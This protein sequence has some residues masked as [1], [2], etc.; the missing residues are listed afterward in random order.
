[1]FR[2]FD[3]VFDAAFGE[4][5]FGKFDVVLELILQEFVRLRGADDVHTAVEVRGHLCDRGQLLLGV[6]VQV[7]RDHDVIV[8]GILDATLLGNDERR[9]TV[10]DN[11]QGATAGQELH[12]LESMSAHDDEVGVLLHRDVVNV[13]KYRADSDRCAH[14]VRVRSRGFFIPG[15]HAQT[16][17]GHLLFGADDVEQHD[18]TFKRLSDDNGVF[19]GNVTHRSEVHRDED[20]V[21]CHSVLINFSANVVLYR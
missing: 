3:G 6:L 7:E 4:V 14:R 9:G 8:S 18:F 17:I 2:D 13:L 21:L 19:K 5:L 10:G 1:M 15:F 20:A 12:A 11:A 16:G